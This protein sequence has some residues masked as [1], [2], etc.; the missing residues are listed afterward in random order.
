MA[1]V[2]LADD[3]APVRDL[4]KHGLTADGH[5]VTAAQDGQEALELLAAAAVPFDV[6]MTDIQMPG[7]DGLTLATKA[8]ALMPKLKVVLMSAYIDQVA[9]PDVLK[10][11]LA[12]VLAKPLA[13]EQARAA[14]KAA[15]S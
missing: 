1:R 9:V 3:E 6:L 4:I 14:I 15:V 13:L 10:P 5:I 8:V 7:M 12:K 2:L 11:R